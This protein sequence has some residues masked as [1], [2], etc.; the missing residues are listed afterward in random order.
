MSLY[1]IDEIARATDAQIVNVSAKT[2]S[3]ISIDSREIE[4]GALYV[5]IKGDKFDGHD[6]VK[7]AI[8]NGAVAALVSSDKAQKFAGLPL[9]IVP[10]ALKGLENIARFARSRTKAK[11]IAITGSAGK[12]STKEA[13][14]EVLQNFGKTHASIK[15]FNNHWGVP[16][17]LARMA[18]DTEYG[19]FELGMNHANEI[20]PLSRLVRPDIAIIT[21]VAP[22]HLEQLGSL[23]NIA[24]AKSEIFDGLEKSGVAII[25]IDHE[26][27]NILLESAKNANVKKIISYGFSDN[28]D[29]QISD[30]VAT[31]VGMKA[32]VNL[33]N[34]Q[35]SLETA[36]FGRHRI[37]NG[38]AALIVADVLR[39]DIKTAL[40]AIFYHELSDG[41]G[42]IYSFGQKDNPLILIDES[43][44]AN[45]LSMRL[46]LEVF[47]DYPTP[48]GSRV[49]ILGDML[50]L[51]ERSGELHAALKEDILKANPDEIYLVGK[52]MHSLAL[53]MGSK[54][55]NYANKINDIEKDILKGLDFGDLVMVKGSNGIKLSGLVELIKKEFASNGK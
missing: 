26:Q 18:K 35:V 10:D 23:E 15:S 28:A 12:T 39:L 25:N 3:S 49:L 1:T 13:I 40:R 8:E 33:P 14:R 47:A 9:I 50:E 53:I 48:N 24:K 19:V 17:M 54:L 41:R 51:G 44:N 5:A 22:A 2:I 30:A 43:Y 36:S 27:A 7:S 20:T 37:A 4:V 32:L 45:P 42:A 6:F 11:I 29:V 46:A 55:E 21:N 34:E 52:S 31:D 38:V 16:L